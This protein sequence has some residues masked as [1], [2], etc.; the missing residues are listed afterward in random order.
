MTKLSK[1]II[2]KDF[3]RFVLPSVIRTYENDG[4]QDDPARCEA[5]NI[6]IDGLKRAGSITESQARRYCIPSKLI[7]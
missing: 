7:K 4:I 5:Y 2:D 3:I 1:S 6:F